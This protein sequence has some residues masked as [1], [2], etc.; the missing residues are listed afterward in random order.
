MLFLSLLLPLPKP[1]VLLPLH[2]FHNRV[3]PNQH[4]LHHIKHLIHIVGYNKLKHT[5]HIPHHIK[6]LLHNS[7]YI[8]P[9]HK[10]LDSTNNLYD[11]PVLHYI[12]YYR[13]IFLLGHLL[14]YSKR[15]PRLYLG[16]YKTIV[17][18]HQH[19]NLQLQLL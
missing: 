13:L 14:D 15:L 2:K 19:L 9:K 5:H 1:L 18:I 10:P 8:L 6:H 3:L 11:Y 4:N 16:D 12:Y 7:D 17:Y